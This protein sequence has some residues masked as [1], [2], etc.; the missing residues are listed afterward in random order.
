MSKHWILMVLVCGLAACGDTADVAGTYTVAVTNGDNGCGFDN[1]TVGDT[2]SNITFSITQDGDMVT[3][4]VE[5]ATGL[6]LGV[7]LGSNVFTGTVSGDE[8]EMTLH[9]TTQGTMGNCSYNVNA[10]IHGEVDGDFLTG[11]IE[12]TTAT[13]GSPECGTLEGCVSMQSFNG[14]RPPSP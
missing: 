7:L 10:T 12:Y 1:W 14:A 9:G 4:T 2:A 8:L 11:H 3:G 6:Y 13:N 5:G